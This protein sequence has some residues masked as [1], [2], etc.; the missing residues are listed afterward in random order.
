ME[1]READQANSMAGFFKPGANA[2]LAVYC[3]VASKKNNKKRGQTMGRLNK[4]DGWIK[5]RRFC[6]KSSCV[7]PVS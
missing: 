6:F 2:F 4:S 5:D 3:R 1:Q 7:I